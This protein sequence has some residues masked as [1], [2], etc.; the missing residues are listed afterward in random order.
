[1]LPLYDEAQKFF[2][3]DEGWNRGLYFEKFFDQWEINSTQKQYKINKK[4]FFIKGIEFDY[5]IET[6][7]LDDYLSRRHHLARILNGRILCSNTIWRLVSGLGATHPIEAGFVWHR[8]LGVPYLPGSSLKG[9]LRAWLTHWEKGESKR[10]QELFGDTD[11]CGQGRLI[12]FDALPTSS[13]KLDLDVMNSHYAPYYENCDKKDVLQSNPPADY[14]SPN[15][16]FFLT[17]APGQG[18]EFMLAPTPRSGTQKDLEEGVTLLKEALS[19]IGVGAKT[20]TGYGVFETEFV[21]QT[22]SIFIKLEEEEEKS[23]LEQLT[24]FEIKCYRL[25]ILLKRYNSQEKEKLKRE[26]I[27]LYGEIESLNE[28]EKLSAA[29]L[30][31]E[32][33]QNIGDWDGKISD[34]Q[35][36]KV[37][38]I[39]K[40]LIKA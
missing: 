21:D 6:N 29:K 14:Y 20:A 23:I 13:V 4:E 11:T 16:V 38:E 10:I 15:P 40:I 22:K 5:K 35:K 17:V 12:V 31:K 25:E 2:Q 39:K 30:L 1:M 8:T 27:S 32:V 3:K 34:K 24:P 36:K 28:V 19:T 33:W 37:E 26:S 9:A 18:F 7:Y